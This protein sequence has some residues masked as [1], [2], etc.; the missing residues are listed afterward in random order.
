[1]AVIAPPSPGRA[2]TDADDRAPTQRSLLIVATIAG[3]VEAF[4]SP[5]ASHFRALGWRVEAAASGASTSPHLAA[6]FDQVHEL[7]LTRSIRDVRGLRRAWQALEKI[8]QA[9]F[10]IVHVHTPIASFL[11]RLAI[12]RLPA[13]R[14]PLVVYT[15]HGFHFH[16]GGHALTN[17]VFLTA[18]RVAGR[19]TDRLVVINDEDE[20]AA[21]RHRLV[22]ERRLVRMPG[23]GLDTRLYAPATVGTADAARVRREL[24]VTPEA[25]LFVIVGEL[26]ANKR[27]ADAI[28]A[29][30]RMRDRE[31]HLVMAGRGPTRSQLLDLAREMGVKDRVHLLGEINDVRPLV[32]ASTALLL[33]SEREGLARSVM[34]A[35]ALEVPVVASAARGNRELLGDDAGQV[36]GIGDVAALAAAMDWMVEHGA[37]RSE[38]GRRGRARMVGAY[39]IR[40]LLQMHEALYADVLAERAALAVAR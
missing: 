1:M 13:E 27:Q 40:L 23:V 30:P 25:P 17:A 28:A 21:R 15:A 9:R 11:T 22:P 33:L 10:D 35:L 3:T 38:M 26:N 24:G 37:E 34:E 4:L 19:W 16:H 39:D 5:Y 2:Q 6:A 12:R 29:L 14:R 8:L 20:A 36:I 7:P 32:R 18:E 31:A